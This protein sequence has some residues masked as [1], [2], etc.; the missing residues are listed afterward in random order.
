MRLRAAQA[1]FFRHGYHL[2]LTI[3]P[4]ALL[5]V[6]GLRAGL[7]V[8]TADRL[9]WLATRAWPPPARSPWPPS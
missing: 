9:R 8:P 3:Q 6:T 2:R 5:E 7:A 1:G 4:G